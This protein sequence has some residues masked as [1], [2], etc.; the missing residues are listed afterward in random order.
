VSP[1]P[2]TA[3]TRGGYRLAAGAIRDVVKKLDKQAA[4]GM[5]WEPEQRELLTTIADECARRALG[6]TGTVADLFDDVAK[7]AGLQ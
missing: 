2:L 6:H 1:K 5:A 4:A 3:A 7:K